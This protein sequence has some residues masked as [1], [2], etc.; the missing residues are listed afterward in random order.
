MKEV[1][2][3]SRSSPLGVERSILHDNVYGSDI[4][5]KF[6]GKGEEEKASTLQRRGVHTK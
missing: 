3:D 1:L 5:M 2:A 4:Y 6:H